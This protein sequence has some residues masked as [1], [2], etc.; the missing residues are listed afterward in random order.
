MGASKL[1]VYAGVE[2]TGGYLIYRVSRVVDVQPD[3]TRQRSV[4]SELGR[5]SGTQEFK[6]FLDGLRADSKVEINK[7]ALEK[8]PQ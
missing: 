7:A 3:E 6:S 5:A 4:Q 1:P 8:K 2:S